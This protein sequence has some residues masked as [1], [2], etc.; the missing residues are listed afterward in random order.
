MIA[1]RNG[2]MRQRDNEAPENATKVVITSNVRKE[3]KNKEIHI[4]GEGALNY[5]RLSDANDKVGG[6]SRTLTHGNEEDKDEAAP[7]V[8]T[9]KRSLLGRNFVAERHE[10]LRMRRITYGP[11]HQKVAESLTSLG[12][13]YH[14]VIQ[15]QNEA[16][17]YHNEALRV[18]RVRQKEI[19][20]RSQMIYRED[21]STMSVASSIGGESTVNA[22]NI[23]SVARA[24]ATVLTDIGNVYRICNRPEEALLSY[25]EAMTIFVDN[26]VSKSYPGMQATM[27]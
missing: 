12:L 13:Y 4:T 18:L 17:R 20:E 22:S 3:D 7:I 1:G 9:D 5:M 21:K 27:R 16:L 2:I 14:H 26:D 15:D 24:M 25:E 11:F 10:E 8:A 19:R 6:S 23:A